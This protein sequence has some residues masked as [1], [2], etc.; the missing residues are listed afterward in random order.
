[1][2]EMGIALRIVDI[3]LG[4]L[5]PTGAHRLVGIRLRLGKLAAIVPRTLRDCFAAAAAGTAA[6]GAELV[7]TEVAIRVACRVC[8]A[9]SE[10][11]ALPWV[12]GAC[13]GGDL[14]IIAGRELVVES[15]EVR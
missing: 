4:S 10:I 1:M 15:I 3:A 9:E 2:H 6:E 8:G 14:E 5:P 12:C 11:E 7:M 13:R